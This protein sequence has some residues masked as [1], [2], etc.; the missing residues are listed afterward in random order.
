MKENSKIRKI[1]F[2][3]NHLPR[4]CG[5][6]T[7]TSDLLAAVATA[8]PLSQC[9]S[10]TCGPLPAG[11]TGTSSGPVSGTHEPLG[12]ELQVNRQGNHQA[13]AKGKVAVC[14]WQDGRLE[15]RY[16][17]QKLSWKEMAERPQRAEADQPRKVPIPYGGTP[18]AASHPWK[19][20]YDGMPEQSLAKHQIRGAALVLA[21]P[22]A[23][24]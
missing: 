24:P 3:G 16:R 2:V 20:R 1:A 22:C 11:S 15:V 13:P 5:I 4:K 17:G 10:E 21:T 8:H 9:F 19:Q 23:T 7:F 12:Q 6:A 18:P 14:E